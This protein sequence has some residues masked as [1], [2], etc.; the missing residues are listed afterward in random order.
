[1][2][3][4]K[5]I[6][7]LFL[8]T[9]SLRAFSEVKF[10]QNDFWGTTYESEK[11]VE[12]Q[13]IT[14]A[15]IA[16]CEEFRQVF[17]ESKPVSAEQMRVAR[18]APLEVGRLHYVAEFSLSSILQKSGEQSRP[19]ELSPFIFFEPSPKVKVSLNQIVDIRLFEAG[20]LTL[21][22]RQLNLPAAGYDL[23]PGGSGTSRRVRIYAR[24]LACDLLSGQSRLHLLSPYELVLSAEM[25]KKIDSFYLQQV[26]MVEEILR[27]TRRPA[28]RALKLGAI[29]G[30]SLLRQSEGGESLEAVLSFIYDKFFQKHSLE[31]NEN[32]LWAP[33]NRF[34]QFD[35]IILTAPEWNPL[36]MKGEK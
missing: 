34:V 5:K 30:Q 11:P 15:V 13:L 9:F 25:L 20:P 28:E 33:P 32:W 29:F 36:I 23:M 14:P 22:A 1:M 17:N 24:D 19:A 2:T 6:I 4:Y 10:V 7:S 21:L 26:Y 16:D 3:S 8:F 18:S 35:K 31:F 12:M 27:L